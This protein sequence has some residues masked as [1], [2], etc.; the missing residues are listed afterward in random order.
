LKFSESR[1]R[2]RWP[3]VEIDI[4]DLDFQCGLAGCDR[5]RVGHKDAALLT[6]IGVVG[7]L[8]CVTQRD[9]VPDQ[10]AGGAIEVK[11]DR[12]IFY[13]CQHNNIGGLS[14]DRLGAAECKLRA[15]LLVIEPK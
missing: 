15:V 14:V 13:V 5:H 2:R 12:H 4:V 1:I 7:D 3:P 6:M 11:F 10:Q 9:L 8:R